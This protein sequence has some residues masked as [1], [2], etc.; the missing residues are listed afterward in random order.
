L[1]TNLAGGSC[2]RT[3]LIAEGV[4]LLQNQFLHAFNA[5]F[6]LEAKVKFLSRNVILCSF[7]D[8]MLTDSQAGSSAG[9]CHT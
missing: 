5:I 8:D 7:H 9:S 6:L 3:D 1:T 2:L 4:H